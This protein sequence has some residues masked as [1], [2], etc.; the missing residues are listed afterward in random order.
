MIDPVVVRMARVWQA[1]ACL[2]LVH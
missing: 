2:A 1:G